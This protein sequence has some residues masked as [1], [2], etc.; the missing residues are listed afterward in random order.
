[1]IEALKLKRWEPERFM[2]W[3]AE[4]EA[5]KRASLLVRHVG[6]QCEV[7]LDLASTPY[8]LTEQ[9]ITAAL[10]AICEAKTRRGVIAFGP[11]RVGVWGVKYGALPKLIEALGEVVECADC[12]EPASSVHER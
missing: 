11:D 1:M 7:S 6:R 3:W 2:A 5:S 4:C 12:L 8:N 9:G 10:A